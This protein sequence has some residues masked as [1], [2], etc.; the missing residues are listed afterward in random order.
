MIFLNYMLS[1]LRRRRGRTILTSLGLAIGIAVVIAVSALSSGLDRAQAKVLEPLTGVGTDMSVSRPITI[2]GDPRTAFQKLSATERAQLRK[3]IGGG[4]IDFGNLTPGSTFTRTTFRASQFSFPETQVTKISSIP[5]VAAAA[6][7]LTL[8]MSTIS[9][10]VPDQA[11]TQPQTGIRGGPPDGGGPGIGGNANFDATT[12]TGV[13]ETKPELGAVTAGQLAKGSY[14]TAGAAREAILNVAFAK[15]K[16]KTVGDTIT[17]A[18]KKFTIVGLAKTPLGGQASDVYVKLAQLQKLSGRTG[19]VN[20]VY[21]R[22]TTAS[23]VAGISKA[24]KASMDNASVTTAETLANQVSGSLS[25]AKDLTKKLG[26]AL[27]LIGLL[28]AVLIASLLTLTSVTKRVRE[29][30]TLKALGWSRRLVVRQVAG[31]SLLQGL[32][33]GVFGVVIGAA[34]AALI[35][36]LAPTLKAT[37]ATAAQS[38]PFPGPF[39]QGAVSSNAASQSVQLVAH[40]SPGVI[41]LAVALAVAGG[42]VAGATGA[43]RASRLRPV[44]ALRHID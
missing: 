22:A 26:F 13:D 14:F 15:T 30:G 21:V 18:K 31:E 17:I 38:N 1:E 42:L 27:E 4:R 16:N 34:A 7:G 6:G 41:A 10:T 39:G 36:A 43:L 40:V 19:R 3:E 12:I 23:A 9:G 28:G 37:V 8:S 20:T 35:T 44:E 2:S 24:I 11:Q 33:G 32:L 25:S 5:D 29:F